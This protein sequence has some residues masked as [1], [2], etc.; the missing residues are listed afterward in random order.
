MK[1]LRV[2][3]VVAALFTL[4][5]LTASAPAAAGLYYQ[6]VTE[7]TSSQGRG[8]QRMVVESRIEGEKARIEF[9]ESSN[10]M[11][12][13]GT[14]LLTTDGGKTLYLVNP[15]EETYTEWDLDAMLKMAGSVMEGLG[16]MVD[17]EF[18]DPEVEQL[19]AEDGG[20]VVGLPTRHYRYRTA[21]SMKIKV[22]GMKRANDVETMQDVWATDELDAAALGIWL[23]KE[24]P[25]TGNEQLDRLIDSEMAKVKGFPLKTVTV[26]TTTGGKRGEKESTTRSEMEVVELRR[27]EPAQPASTWEIPSGYQKT[28]MMPAG[29]EGEEGNPF[30][31][32]FGR[33][34]DG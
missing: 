29:E 5:T 23:R 4:L 25:K 19:L 30:K 33:K 26:S 3:T 15:K 16:G 11:T 13:T 10:P 22:F 18:T 17:M 6:A 27:D 32:L 24:P 21:Y 1:P 34:K 28:E 12:G 7:T 31:G 2:C 9:K 20:Q 8:A 14:Y